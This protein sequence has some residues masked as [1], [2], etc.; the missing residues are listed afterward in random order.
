M[1]EQKND[2]RYQV[3]A[4]GIVI[5]SFKNR[6]DMPNLSRSRRRPQFVTLISREVKWRGCAPLIRLPFQS[7]FGTAWVPN[8]KNQRRYS[9]MA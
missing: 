9:S 7:L 4:D 5:P 2:L 6:A 8:G 3:A 1:K